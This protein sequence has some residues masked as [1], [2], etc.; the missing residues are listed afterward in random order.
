L[1]LVFVCF[2]PDEQ[3]GADYFRAIAHMVYS[4]DA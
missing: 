2:S 1:P 3:F 4:L